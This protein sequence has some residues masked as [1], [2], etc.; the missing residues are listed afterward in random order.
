MTGLARYTQRTRKI[1]ETTEVR[2]KVKRKK[3]QIVFR[4]NLLVTF[5]FMNVLVCFDL[6]KA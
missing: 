4:S 1:G 5:R 2:L 3:I 6:S